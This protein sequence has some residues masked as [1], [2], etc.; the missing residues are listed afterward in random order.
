MINAENQVQA[1][2]LIPY[3]AMH[4]ETLPFPGSRKGKALLV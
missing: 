2:K 1:S 4:I 3:V